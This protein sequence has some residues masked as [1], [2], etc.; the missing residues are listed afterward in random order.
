MTHTTMKSGMVTGSM[1]IRL[2]ESYRKRYGIRECMKK[3]AFQAAA[4]IFWSFLLTSTGWLIWNYRVHE[5]LPAEKANFVTMVPGYL[6]QAVGIGF[7]AYLLRIA[8]DCVER[9]FFIAV[10][11]HMVFMIPAAL[12]VNAPGIAAGLF[13]EFFCGII[14]GY[15]LYYYAGKV[16]RTCRAKVFGIGYGLSVLISWLLTLADDSFYFSGKILYACLV[17][18]A[19]TVVTVRLYPMN[20]GGKEPKSSNSENLA[21]LSAENPPTGED[22][23]SVRPAAKA[24]AGRKSEENRN[25]YP[26]TLSGRYLWLKGALVLLLGVVINCGFTFC[27][28]SIG[29]NVNVELTRLVYAQ[30]LA[31]AGIVTDRDRKRGAVCA[32]SAL[33]FPFIMLSL[34]G[35]TIPETV[36]WMLSYFAFGFYSVYRIVLFSD[37][38][39]LYLSGFGLMIGR[40]ADALGEAVSL[41][42]HEHPVIHVGFT[43]GMCVAAIFVFFRVY[44]YLYVP[45][46]GCALGDSKEVSETVSGTSD[47]DNPE[48]APVTAADDIAEAVTFSAMKEIAETDILPETAMTREDR[49]GADAAPRADR[50]E[51]FYLFAARYALSPRER[52]ILRLILDDKTNCE[53]ADSL[54]ISENTVKFHVK[55]ILKKTGYRN[56]NGIVIAYSELPE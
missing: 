54:Y 41:L 27:P 34:R 38:E 52:D 46:M 2:G 51:R 14:A 56:R 21:E 30:S 33:V 19:C 39:I 1:Q 26:E 6:L 10:I 29:D 37:T 16:D 36:F 23:A 12:S 3:P 45:E 48:A 11:L 7:F 28:V 50:E 47:P 40:V 20:G 5:Y 9:V 43:A 49:K 31:A 44:H 17:M 15:Y 18:T 24:P 22:M 55:N 8:A 4:V 42:L 35:E 32:L 13:M 25:G 53:I